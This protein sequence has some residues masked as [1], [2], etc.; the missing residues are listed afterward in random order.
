M[1]LFNKDKMV[2]R[3]VK[4]RRNKTDRKAEKGEIHMKI[5]GEKVEVSLRLFDIFERNMVFIFLCGSC[6]SPPTNCT[7]R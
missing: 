7:L 2:Y 1:P 4:D 6:E 3:V 5:I